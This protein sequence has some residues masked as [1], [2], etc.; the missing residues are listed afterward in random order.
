MQW[1]NI[2]DK[3]SNSDSEKNNEA[4]VNSGPLETG[5]RKGQ[6]LDSK[7]DKHDSQGPKQFIPNRA[8]GYGAKSE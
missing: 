3:L 7:L 8:M 2:F 5:Q 4:V 1:L 6:S